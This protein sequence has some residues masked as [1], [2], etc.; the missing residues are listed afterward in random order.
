MN[1]CYIAEGSY[2]YVLGGV[3]SWIQQLITSMPEFTFSIMAI[4]A[5][6]SQLGTFCYKLPKNV[7]RIIEIPIDVID[8]STNKWGK[9]LMLDD[10]GKNAFVELLCGGDC[11]WDKIFSIITN[12]SSKFVSSLILSKDFFDISEVACGKSYF[13][14]PFTEFYWNVRSMVLPLLQIFRSE[15]PVADVYHSVSTGYAGI[16][17]AYL[18]YRTN[19]PLLLTEHG[20]YSRERE[21]ELIKATWLKSYCKNMW[22]NYFYSLSKKSYDSADKVLTLFSKNKEIEIEL[23]CPEKKIEIIPNGVEL[24]NFNQQQES[25]GE[26]INIGA[27][28]RV[29]PI[30]DIFTLIYSFSYAKKRNKNIKLFIMGPNEEEKDYYNE[31]L[32]LVKKLGIND[33]IFTG[34]VSITKWISK[35]DIIILTSISEGQPFAILEAMAAKKPCVATNV[36]SCGELLEGY[37][38]GIGPAGII[39]T[40]MDHE[41]IGK[42]LYRLS[43]DEPLREKMGNAGYKRVLAAY[44]KEQMIAGYRDLYKSYEV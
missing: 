3:S 27:I 18:K 31:C 32:V 19:K 8:G 40:V 21:E 42:A 28:V 2:P 12:N 17:G 24:K 33:V 38:E 36:G 41:S 9:R 37:C 20:L 44:T 26:E 10:E 11:E 15:Y 22:I 34:T 25:H 29:V 30:K 6:K 43:I 39:C 4:C 23:G 5:K 14:V 35:M 7:N 1:I 13:Y 16:L